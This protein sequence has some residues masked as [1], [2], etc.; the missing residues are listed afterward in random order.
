MADEIVDLLKIKIEK[1]KAGL[2]TETLNAIATVDWRTAILGLRGRFG[3]TFEQLGDLEL[4]TELLLSGLVSPEDYPK[5]LGNRM[6][7]SKAAA[8]ELVNEMNS[9]VFKK[10][11]EELIK[12]AERKKIFA[13]SSNI[14][15]PAVEVPP[16]QTKGD[17]AILSGAGI[18]II[19]DLP[20]VPGVQLMQAG[21]L[22]LGTV[23]VRS[24]ES[25]ESSMEKPIENKEAMLEKIEKPEIAQSILEQKLTS[26]FQIPMVKTE[27]SLDNITPTSK[28]IGVP[29]PTPTPGRDISAENVG[30]K[31]ANETKTPVPQ[32]PKSYPKNSDPYRLSPDE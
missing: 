8:N 5:E 4:E 25:S 32:A 15:T 12:N 17:S 21:K 18:E 9:L 19:P 20:A 24:S 23:S 1:A 11:R 16:V 10:I 6:K 31:I 14:P 28:G 3:Y 27:H 29:I 30:T 13:K 7:I 22:E 26:S 2:S